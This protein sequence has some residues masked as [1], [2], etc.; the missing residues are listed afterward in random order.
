MHSVSREVRTSR[1]IRPAMAGLRLA[2][3]FYLCYSWHTM[4][5]K[6]DTY[7]LNKV[8]TSAV[9]FMESYNKSV[10]FGFPSVSMK[11]LK[12]FQS[13]HPTLFKHGDTWSIDRHRKRLMDWLIS[14][15]DSV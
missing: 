4:R 8:T 13:V 15:H 10:P 14:H 5:R 7:E 3:L 12:E 11:A 1:D 6:N 2:F 9:V